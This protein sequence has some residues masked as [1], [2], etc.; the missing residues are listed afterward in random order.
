[1]GIQIIE[2]VV[3]LRQPSLH[4]NR[5]IRAT[6]SPSKSGDLANVVIDRHRE[7][8]TKILVAWALALSFI[9]LSAVAQTWTGRSFGNSQYLIDPNGNIWTGHRVGN[10]QTWTDP[11][12]G[13]Q[14]CYTYG[15]ITNCN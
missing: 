14:T 12:G 2:G 15:S 7:M 8:T 10:T 13:T 3:L 6:N 9:T 5:P 11:S 1:M 4:A